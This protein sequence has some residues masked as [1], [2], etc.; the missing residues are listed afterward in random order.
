M[1]GPLEGRVAE[2]YCAAVVARSAGGPV[3]T[4]ARRAVALSLRPVVEVCTMPQS[5]LRAASIAALS[6]CLASG[7]LAVQRGT[8]AEGQRFISGGV[9]DEET[10]S[11]HAERESYTLW[12]VTAAKK[13]GAYLA[14][15]RIKAT[16]AQQKVVF[17]ADR[18]PVADDRSA[19]GPLCGRGEFR[20]RDAA[21]RDHHSPRRP[22][23]GHLLLRD[24][25]GR[26]AGAEG[27]AD[28]LSISTTAS[29]DALPSRRGRRWSRNQVPARS[30]TVSI[31]PA[32]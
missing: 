22:S 25:G 9:S 1:T 27:D 2:A 26:V 31:A 16:D 5:T 12:V 15:A 24:P 8:T 29:S 19:A 13:T 18:R 6:L 14:D 32:S 4:R 3:Q 21:T 20:R 17:D 10:T 11:M 28:A 30:A 23:P 7:A